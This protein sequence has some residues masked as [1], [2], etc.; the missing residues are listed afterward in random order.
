MSDKH[1]TAKW[2]KILCRVDLATGK[3]EAETKSG[4]RHYASLTIA[5]GTI[6]KPSG[7]EKGHRILSSK[8]DELTC[9]EVWP[10]SHM[11]GG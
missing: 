6:V 4:G 5:D 7:G 8:S 1:E 10:I 3:I 9:S 2:K 11:E